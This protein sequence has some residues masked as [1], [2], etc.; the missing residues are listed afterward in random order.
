MNKIYELKI[1]EQIEIKDY[2]IIRVPGGW[3]YTCISTG[4]GFSTFIPFCSPNL[5]KIYSK[6]GILIDNKK[7]DISL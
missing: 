2:K 1:N 5:N 3:I 6:N 4:C 7:E